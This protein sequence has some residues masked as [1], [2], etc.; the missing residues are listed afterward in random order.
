M[1]LVLARTTGEITDVFRF[2]GVMTQESC[3]SSITVQWGNVLERSG[4]PTL[5]PTTV[6][7]RWIYTEAQ[8][9]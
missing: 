4:H 8:S 3:Y 5:Y 7:Q 6:F 9:R 1:A 2:I